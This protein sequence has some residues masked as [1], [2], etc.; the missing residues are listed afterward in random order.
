MEFPATTAQLVPKDEHH[1]RVLGLPR[2]IRDVIWEQALVRR[3]KIYIAFTSLSQF[4]AVGPVVKRRAWLRYK[5]R[6]GPE[7]IVGSYFRWDVPPLA[8]RSGKHGREG[9]RHHN[10]HNDADDDL[11]NLN[12][13]Y[14]NNQVCREAMEVY[15]SRNTFSFGEDYAA[16]QAHH[17]YMSGE[18]GPLAAYAFLRDRTPLALSQIRHVEIHALGSYFTCT[19]DSTGKDAWGSLWGVLCAMKNLHT[20]RLDLGAHHLSRRLL[21]AA[22]GDHHHHH[23]HLIHPP[24][25]AQQLQLQRLRRL[26]VTLSQDAGFR[27]VNYRTDY[28]YPDHDVASSAVFIRTLRSRLIRGGYQ[29]GYAHIRAGVRRGL[30][31]GCEWGLP[32]RANLTFESSDEVSGGRGQSQQKRRR[33]RRESGVDE[34]GDEEGDEALL[35]WRRE[36][37]LTRVSKAEIG[38]E[39]SSFVGSR[40]DRAIDLERDWMGRLEKEERKEPWASLLQDLE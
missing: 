39:Q 19:L 36:K 16:R 7:Q 11:E 12:L 37:G 3:S 25:D 26:E 14:V 34:E 23:H 17:I 8:V 35:V 27:I 9:D 18:L 24:H 28:N 6:Y 13:L 38:T 40:I 21:R 5:R 32:R 31:F 1:F 33:R 15:Y 4:P 30:P 22:L 2:E 20:L 10:D 29:L